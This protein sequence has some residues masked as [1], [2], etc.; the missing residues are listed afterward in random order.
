MCPPGRSRVDVEGDAEVEPGELVGR[1]CTR[2]V[3][4]VAD[5]FSSLRSSNP[6]VK[7]RKP[8]S[9]LTSA[10]REELLSRNCWYRSRSALLNAA[11]HAEKRRNDGSSRVCASTPVARGAASSVV[12]SSPPMHAEPSAVPCR[13]AHDE[14]A[15][16]DH[17]S[18]GTTD[19]CTR[20]SGRRIVFRPVDD[21]RELMER[22]ERALNAHGVDALVDC[23]HEDLYSEDFGHPA[24]SFQGRG[25]CAATGS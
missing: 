23:F 22:Q 2:P 18:H 17:G 14:H 6:P 16:Y 13:A 20:L 25:T 9:W 10:A 8:I 12:S 4:S 19:R 5:A 11:S 7:S 21:I 15:P 3:S 1:S 24:A